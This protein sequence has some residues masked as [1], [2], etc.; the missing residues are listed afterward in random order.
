M[1]LIR[2][3]KK[4]RQI[5]SR[6]QKI[7]IIGLGVLMV[8]GGFMEMLSVTLILPFIEA[9]M[10]P[11]KIMAN[12]YIRVLCGAF[13]IESHRTFLVFMALV[14]AALYVLKNIFLLL[15]M[16]IQQRFVYNNRFATQQSLLRNYLLRP[17]EFFLEV[18]SGEVLRVI[19]EDTSEAF[20]VLT[21]LLSLISELVVSV[22]LLFTA[23]VISPGMTIEMAA[24]LLITVF[25]IQRVL[26]P[27]LER[28]GRTYQETSAGMHQWLIQSIQG[29]KE[30]KI[31]RCEKY[32]ESN[33][34]KNGR[35]AV[36]ASYLRE[37]L[38]LVPRFMIEAAA[39]CSFFVII[40]AMIY[41]GN[42]LE[43]IIP[44]LSGLAMAA[45]RLL[46]AMNRISACMAGITFREPA[47]DKMI[48]NLREVSDYDVSHSDERQLKEKGKRIQG[49][50]GE[51]ELLDITY[52]YPTGKEDVLDGAAMEI[53]KGTSVGIV[54]V[55][56]AGKTT[57][58]DI[59]L[60]LLRPQKGEVLIDG[61]DISLDM[62]GW[63][64]EIGYIPQFIFMLDGDI[65]ENVAFGIPD[66][67]ID[68]DMVWTAL[69]EA[70]LA[71]FVRSL[72]EGL[73]TQ[74]GE[75]GIRLSGGQRQR[76][77]IARALYSNPS[78]LFFDEA[79]SAL[80]NETEAVIMDSINHLHGTKTM[81]IIAHRLTTI[82]GCDIIYRVESGKIRRER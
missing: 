68:D 24:A 2:V 58:V 6:H 28:A 53:Q 33:F 67:D 51:I 14:M 27:L 55:S 9:V 21:Q 15:Q 16:M 82:E 50:S 11:E 60:G 59:L 23:F 20:Y 44:I 72:P 10:T 43:R 8:I 52:R 49:L 26:R 56:G 17:Y 70:A 39:M 18:K 69:E 46:P 74:L 12:R 76:L 54:G 81:V 30:I 25:L 29:I 37:T 41:R 73:Y 61:T 1:V 31:M 5:L 13:G 62:D 48:E 66:D 19:G 80:D 65:R 32:F 42:P 47:V 78:I 7:R 22:A 35:L 63:L 36:R 45:V 75:R 34:E 79:T 40:A 38:A 3:L 57:A 4:F 71:E 64:S 77:G